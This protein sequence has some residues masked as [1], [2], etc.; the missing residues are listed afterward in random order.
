MGGGDV[1]DTITAHTW[2]MRGNLTFA[3]TLNAHPYASDGASI[4]LS[5]DPSVGPFGAQ[6]VGVTVTD[7]DHLVAQASLQVKASLQQQPGGPD[8]K[9][10]KQNP[11]RPA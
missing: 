10:S 5:F 4:S 3:W 11:I 2:D 1:E 7:E 6:N 8:G 9:T